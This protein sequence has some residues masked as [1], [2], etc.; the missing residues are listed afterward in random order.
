MTL[1]GGL[2]VTGRSRP[3]VLVVLREVEDLVP[4]AFEPTNI[5]AMGLSVGSSIND[6]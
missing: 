4:G 2:R 5:C 1:D 6:P 3:R